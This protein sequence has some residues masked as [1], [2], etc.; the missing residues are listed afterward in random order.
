[1]FSLITTL[2]VG[3]LLLYGDDL[4]Q[5]GAE[6]L[7]VKEVE[8]TEQTAVVKVKENTVLVQEVCGLV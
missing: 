1:M 2:L 3:V 7:G 5:V 6:P 8:I 4:C